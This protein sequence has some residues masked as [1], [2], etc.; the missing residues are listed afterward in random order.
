[1]NEYTKDKKIINYLAI[2]EKEKGWRFKRYLSNVGLEDSR[3]NWI[4]TTSGWKTKLNEINKNIHKQRNSIADISSPLLGTKVLVRGGNTSAEV[5]R[6]RTPP[7][8]HP[9]RGKTGGNG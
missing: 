5:W 7:T 9:R 4:S 8:H 6:H 1:M 2:T 3:I